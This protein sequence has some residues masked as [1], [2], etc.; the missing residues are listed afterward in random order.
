AVNEGAKSTGE[1]T[2]EEQ[3]KRDEYKKKLDEANAKAKKAKAALYKLKNAQARL[4]AA[5]G[6]KP[7]PDP[8]QNVFKTSLLPTPGELV[9]G[10]PQPPI[11]DGPAVDAPGAPGTPATNDCD[12]RIK[13]CADQIAEALRGALCCC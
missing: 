2:A 8:G 10:V 6:D 9:G 13:E 7:A 3:A 1:K 4:A 5:R 11:W 12:K